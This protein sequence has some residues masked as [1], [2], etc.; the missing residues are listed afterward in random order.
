MADLILP[1]R[2]PL[3]TWDEY[4]GKQPIVSSMQPA[5]GKMTKASQ[6]GD[7]LLHTGF[8]NDPPAPNY[9]DWLISR[10]AEG[11][12]IVNEAQWVRTLQQGG[13][14][15]VVIK[16]AK[17]SKKLKPTKLADVLGKK[18][19]HPQ[20]DLVFTAMP[21]IKFFDGRGANKPWLCEIPDPLSRIAWQ[22][23]VIIH[24]D[25]AKQK[26]I[27]QQDIIQIQS[28]TGTLEAPV[29][30]SETVSP[31]VMVMPIGQGHP[32][33]GRYARD[34]GLN[35]VTLLSAQTDRD[36]GG[37]SF[38]MDRVSIKKTGQIGRASCREV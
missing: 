21:S 35:P 6:L 31:F 17:S 1:F 29:Y 16:T 33:Y 4:S 7:V 13:Q 12:G 25:T 28:E 32:S 19:E 30:L 18:T 15:R 20:S 23:P 9:K 34:T 5:M 2:M 8:E 37:C 26:G 36:S 11:H 27:A 22:T 10:L 14:F 38:T 24:P 3:E